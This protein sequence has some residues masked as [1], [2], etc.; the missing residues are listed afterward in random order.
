MN[1]KIVSEKTGLT[2]RAIKYY[3][4]QDLIN[5]YKNNDNNYREYTDDDV[6]KLN[7]IGALRAMDIPICEIKC[8]LQGDKNLTQIMEDTLKKI[9]KTISNLEKSKVVITNIIDKNLQDYSS[10]GEQATKLRETL[11]LSVDKK[12]EL[13]CNKLLRTFPGNCGK[14]LVASYEPFLNILVDPAE[15][16]KA[17]LKLVEILDEGEDVD[18]DDPILEG[19]DGIDMNFVNQFKAKSK[20]KIE[21]LLSDDSDKKEKH[22]K[23]TV[24]FIKLMN[25]NEEVRNKFREV[26]NKSSGAVN[27]IR[28]YENNFCEYLEILS[29]DYKKYKETCKQVN[30]EIKSSL[31]L[32]LDDVLKKTTKVTE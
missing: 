27:S 23:D 24:S 13:L 11:E 8:L 3:E 14:I 29:E 6:I 17:W 5:P 31:G 30:E 21:D 25:E 18:Y 4:I 20:K 12:K 15:K 32:N 19:I 9:M 7:L 1:I 2:K 28:K 26:L 16:E 10:I 22:K